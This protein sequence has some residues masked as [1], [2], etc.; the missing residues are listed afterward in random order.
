MQFN[1]PS[2]QGYSGD[3]GATDASGTLSFSF[4]FPPADDATKGPA[5]VYHVVATCVSGTTKQFT[6]TPVAFTMT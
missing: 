4:D 6:Y 1:D 5:G 2:G 3:G